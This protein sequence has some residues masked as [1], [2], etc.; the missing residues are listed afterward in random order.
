MSRRAALRDFT[1]GDQLNVTL[2]R[3][4][5]VRAARHAARARRRSA[6]HAPGRA[7]CRSAVRPSRSVSA[8]PAS[9]TK[10]SAAARSQSWLLPAAKATSSCAVRR[11]ARAAAPASATR[12]FGTTFGM[13]RRRAARAWR[14]GAGDARAVE[15]GAGARRDRHAVA[16]SRPRRPPRG[17]ARRSTGANSAASDRPAVLDQRHRDRSSPVAAGDDRRACRRSD[18][19][20]RPRRACS[21]ARIVLGLFRQPAV[22]GARPCSRS[23]QQIRRPRCRLR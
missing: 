11:R 14:F 17:T 4:H 2:L 15:R 6:R 23:L 16:A 3:P 22:A 5:Q 18:R 1:V 9:C 21:R 20:P 12:G 7:D 8:P 19:R 13:Q 10:R